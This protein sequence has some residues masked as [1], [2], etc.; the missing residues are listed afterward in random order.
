MR[1]RRGGGCR[2]WTGPEPWNAGRRQTQGSQDMAVGSLEKGEARVSSTVHM[3]D[4]G[5]Q[6]VRQMVATP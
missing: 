2:G 6:G 3:G 5:A 1:N 4:R